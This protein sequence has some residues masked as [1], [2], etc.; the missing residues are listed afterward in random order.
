M[1]KTYKEL[2]EGKIQN[3]VRFLDQESKTEEV[4]HTIQLNVSERIEESLR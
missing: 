4:F 1:E 3:V 2:F